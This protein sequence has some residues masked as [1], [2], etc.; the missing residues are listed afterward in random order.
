M[1]K[2][3]GVVLSP[4]VRKVLLTLEYKGIPY[5][6]ISVFPGSEEPEFRAI[7]PLGKIPILEDDGFIVPDTSVIC[8]YLDRT[9]PEKSI[10][11][12]DAKLEA[13][14]CWLEEFADSKLI[15]ACAGLFRQKFLNPMM[16]NTPTD[17]AAVADILENQM[18]GLLSY[19][20]SQTPDSGVLV[21]DSVSVA[22]IAVLTCFLQARYGD[23]EVDGDTYPKLKAYLDR[24]LESDVVKER[25]AK[26]KEVVAALAA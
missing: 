20:E 15:D 22:D 7:S 11:P 10:Y 13:Q 4:F 19:L 26:E 6:S 25:M 1:I 18:P 16:F 3:H 2:V 21:G 9:H 17:E 24:C 12:A 5:E 8:R 14:A 23:F